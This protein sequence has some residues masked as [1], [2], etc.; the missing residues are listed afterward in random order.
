MEHWHLGSGRDLGV[1]L[2]DVAPAL[3]LDLNSGHE[4]M[5]WNK[6]SVL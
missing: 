3:D 2:D 5:G 6:N 4:R 1:S